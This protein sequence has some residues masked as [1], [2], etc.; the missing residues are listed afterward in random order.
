MAS[1]V[2]PAV[3]TSPA[4]AAPADAVAAEEA[5]EEEGGG[6]AYTVEQTEHMASWPE[7]ARIDAFCHL[8]RHARWTHFCVP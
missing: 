6:S 8:R 2:A 4:S 3:A 7:H 5:E 1:T